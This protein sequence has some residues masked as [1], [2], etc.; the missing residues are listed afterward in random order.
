MTRQV[1]GWV[2]V[3]AVTVFAL[4]QAAPPGGQ[5]QR[6]SN[7][8]IVKTAAQR[9]V[10]TS[11]V[12]PSDTDSPTP[13]DTRRKQRARLSQ[14]AGGGFPT[15]VTEAVDYRNDEGTRLRD[16]GLLEGPLPF[17]SN[18][19]SSVANTVACT[20]D[21]ECDD[22]DSCT[23]DRC[24]FQA[25][26]LPG[27]G[28]CENTPAADGSDGAHGGDGCQL[29]R[30]CGGCDD[31]IICNGYEGCYLGVCLGGVPAACCDD[32]DSEVGQKACSDDLA[33]CDEDSVNAGDVC[34]SDA[35]CP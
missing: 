33:R 11:R 3:S 31:G 20:F 28:K 21:I 23:N 10:A 18:D 24:V 30:L 4:A 27:S 25:G 12:S 32:L 29:G 7:R 35:D 14:L 1:T 22:G 2:I 8:A 19:A 26:G 5:G 13:T 15:I 16:A 6:T 17:L 34:T 9:S